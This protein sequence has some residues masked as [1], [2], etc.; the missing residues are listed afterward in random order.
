MLSGV[1][2]PDGANFAAR[3]AA[4]TGVCGGVI[5]S[6]NASD[7]AWMDLV[8]EDV[9]AARE[10]ALTGGEPVGDVFTGL[11]ETAGLYGGREG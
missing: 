8:V 4:K 9:D 5:E 3:L 1:T 7:F 11:V 10:S 6:S 2:T